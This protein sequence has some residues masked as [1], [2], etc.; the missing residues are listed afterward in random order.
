MASGS[1]LKD[2][3]NKKTVHVIGSRIQ[4]VYPIFPLDDF[5]SD[6]MKELPSLELMNRAKLITRVLHKYLP[7]SYPEAVEILCQSL[8]GELNKEELEGMKGFL[9]LPLN[10]YVGE[11]GK[12]YF[13]LSMSAI[14]KLTKRFSCEW[15][16]R[17]YILLN[18]DRTFRYLRK[19]V[20]DKDPFV[21]RLVSE[22]TRPRLPW[23]I[24]LPE[25][26]RNPED[27]IELLE[28]LKE[29]PNL[30][31]RR[32][33]ANNINDIS[34]DNPDVA[35]ALIRRWSK[36]DNEGTKWLVK[37]ASRSLVKMG[38]PEILSILG[39]K[40][41]G[42]IKVNKF[43]LKKKSV[44]LGEMLEFSFE[45]NS[46]QGKKSSLMIDYCIHFL[47][48]SGKHSLK[49]FKLTKKEQ[50]N[51]EKLFI[52]KKHPLKKIT[53]RKMYFGKHFVEIIINGKKY[54]RKEFYL[55]GA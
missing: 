9:I 17:Q 7:V 28:C 44:Q 1:L 38:N 50:Y 20:K 40:D 37:H 29:D 21:R 6:V 27:V 15:D 3:Y 25:F 13:D 48:A 34:K 54:G 52:T 16:I 47:K 5:V 24:R 14:Y 51:G 18:K 11:Y 4:S 53:T 49:I 41:D 2:I 42:Y 43:T 33:V 30:M 45:I 46:T 55:K 31:V 23:G 39:Y 12:E 35:V 22:G 36:F 32:S 19:W 26:Q 10:M 8:P